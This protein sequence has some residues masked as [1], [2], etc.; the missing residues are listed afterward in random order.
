[1]REPYTRERRDGAVL[2]CLPYSLAPLEALQRIAS[3][4][5]K[6]AADFS[7]DKEFYSEDFRQRYAAILLRERGA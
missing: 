4:R 2:Y 1:M 7:G 3:G 5:M 6:M